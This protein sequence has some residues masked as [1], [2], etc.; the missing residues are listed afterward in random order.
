[1]EERLQKLIAKAGL[2]SRRGA[3]KWIEQGRVT[4]NGTV[5]QLGQRANPSKDRICIDGQPLA[6]AETKLTVMLNKPRGYVST[7]KDPQ[8]RKRVS[9]LL[10]SV[11]QRLYPIGRLD[12]NTEGMLLMTNDGALAQHLSHPRNHVDKTYLVKARGDMTED[13]AKRIERG[14]ELDDGMTAPAKVANIRTVG[15]YC[16]FELTIHEGRNRQ[17]RRMCEIL[18][19]DVLRLKRIRIGFL[20]LDGVSTGAFRELSPAEI[21]RLKTT[22]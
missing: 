4:V 11:E 22:T 18:G 7:L 3:E 5:A 6:S 19:L 15:A 10:K 14:I 20:T 2:T 21:G 13:M 1:M 17:V 9:D 8:G 12:Y 16:W